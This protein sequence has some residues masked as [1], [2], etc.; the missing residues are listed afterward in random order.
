[1][2]KYEFP[3]NERIR[4][5]LRIEEIFQKM[6]SQ[7]VIKSDFSDYSCFDTFFEIMATASRADLKVELIQE[8]EKQRSK[9][10]IKS[11]T[12]KN[13]AIIKDLD[14][15]R[16]K[17]EKSKVIAGSNFGG[18]KFLTELKT[19]AAS[20]FGI[21]STDFPEFQYWLQ[22]TTI[23]ERKS[24]FN[25]QIKDFIPIKNAI[26][27]LM[28]LLRG[29]IHTKS[30]STKSGSLQYKLDPL[31]KN[32]LVAITVGESSRF[33]PNISS[34]KYAVNVHFASKG[35]LSPTSSKSVK[36]KL[37]IASF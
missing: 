23:S 7:M 32:D 27:N 26:S 25:S 4:K 22:K 34:N 21:V 17:L 8:I 31:L 35:E 18:D 19:R 3:L 20:P 5:F 36:F 37:G 28:K 13:I 11:K 1:M 29:N 33:Y 16:K 10:K 6:D 12:K 9:M 24:Y 15:T 14:I 2:I 30:M